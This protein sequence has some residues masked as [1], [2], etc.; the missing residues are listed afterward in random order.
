MAHILTHIFKNECPDCHKGKVF[1]GN[2]LL[3][4]GLPKMHAYCSHCHYKFRKEPGYFFGAMYVSY[5]LT[6]AQAIATYFIASPFFNENFD[7]KIIPVIAIVIIL[8]APF[9]IRMSRLLWIYMFKS[10]S[11]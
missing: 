1:I 10:Y 7:P 8:L 9:N 4:P 2:N 3:I 5:A 11:T 6:V